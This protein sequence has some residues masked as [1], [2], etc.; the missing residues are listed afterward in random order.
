M[1]TSS[2]NPVHMCVKY[3]RVCVYIFIVTSN[4]LFITCNLCII[5]ITIHNYKVHPF[6]T[7]KLSLSVSLLWISFAST[8]RCFCLLTFGE[9]ITIVNQ[10]ASLKTLYIYLVNHCSYIPLCVCAC[11]VLV[12]I[13]KQMLSGYYA[14]YCANSPHLWVGIIFW[15]TSPDLYI[16][17]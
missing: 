14:F 16:T 11:T 3:V 5:I 7:Y 2:S 12:S 13:F 10:K 6:I 9:T 15:F 8:F 4:K 1:P 17:E